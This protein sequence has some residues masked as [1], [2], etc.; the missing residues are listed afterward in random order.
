MAPSGSLRTFSLKQLPGGEAHFRSRSVN[1]FIAGVGAVGGTLIKQLNQL[2]HRRYDLHVIGLCNN[3]KV[4][5]REEEVSTDELYGGRAKNWSEILTHL[6][7]IRQEN[8][9]LI[10][11]DVTGSREVA[12]LYLELLESGIHVVTPSKIANTLEFEYF[13]KLKRAAD[14]RGINYY[15]EATVGAGLPVIHSIENLLES[16]DEIVDVTGVLSG[17]MTYL[18]NELEQGSP[19][20][21]AVLQARKLGYAE[22]DPRDDLSGEDVARKFLIIARTCGLPLERSQ[23]DVQSLIPDELKRV[24][25]NEFISRFPEYDTEWSDRIAQELQNKRTLRYT[26]S[27][28]NG[29]VS[30]GIEAVNQTSALGS[31]T[32]TNNLVQIRTRR[33]YDQPLIIQGPGAGKEVTAAGVL[34][35]IQK[36][37]NHL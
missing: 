28:S 20:S 3:T 31:L 7:E 5:W 24:D 34:A 37:V 10:F 8:R 14:D 30:I 27:L 4:K 1:L 35:D 11:V 12:D 29:N 25:A 15:Y 21:R 36:I 26:G 17:T 16:G 32:G 9:P 2:D 6:R 19:F 13:S 23:I 33:Y 22:P 18:F